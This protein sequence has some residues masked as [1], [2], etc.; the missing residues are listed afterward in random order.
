MRRREVII[1]IGGTAIAGATRNARAAADAGVGFLSLISG[2]HDGS[3][4]ATGVI[5]P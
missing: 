5:S 3:V 1:H 4:D 2:A